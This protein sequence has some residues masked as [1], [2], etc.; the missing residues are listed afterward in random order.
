M[1]AIP[2]DM[3]AAMVVSVDL[4][5]GTR[6]RLAGANP[7]CAR[8]RQAASTRAGKLA[9]GLAD[10]AIGD[11]CKPAPDCCAGAEKFTRRGN[12]DK[13]DVANTKVFFKDGRSPFRREERRFL[14]LPLKLG[15]T[16]IQISGCNLT[17]APY[18]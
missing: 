18:I 9:T 1:A 17:R 12:I 13:A 8:K 2:A 11:C 16:E 7:R 3:A 5:N 14:T 10:C 6:G 15:L 4:L